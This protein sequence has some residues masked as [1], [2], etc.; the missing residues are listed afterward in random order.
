MDFSVSLVTLI[1]QTW[2]QFFLPEPGDLHSL[3]KWEPIQHFS[4]VSFAQIGEAATYGESISREEYTQSVT[5]YIRKC[6]EN[7]TPEVLPQE[8]TGSPG[9]QQSSVFS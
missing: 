8:P 2:K 1:T 5:S 4:T 7:V 3:P 6:V 9:S